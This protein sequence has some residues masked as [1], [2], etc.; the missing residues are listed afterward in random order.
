ME[1]AKK[2][3]FLKE[4]ILDRQF[5]PHKFEEFLQSKKEDGADIGE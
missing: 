5:L 4:Q 1:R 2:Q 3:S